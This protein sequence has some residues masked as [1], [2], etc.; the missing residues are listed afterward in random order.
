MT[1]KLAV[2]YIKHKLTVVYIKQ[3]SNCPGKVLVYKR[4]SNNALR[5]ARQGEDWASRNDRCPARVSSS[6]P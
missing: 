3:Y 1:S 4:L 5:N 6:P 2:V